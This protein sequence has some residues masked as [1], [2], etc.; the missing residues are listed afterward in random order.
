MEGKKFLLNCLLLHGLMILAMLTTRAASQPNKK[1]YIVYLGNKPKDG[2]S[3]SSLHSSILKEAFGSDFITK[4]V[5]CSYKRS[6]DGFV[7]ELTEEEAL[8]M[9]RMKG[10][11]S[12]FPNEKRELHTTRSWDFMG[13]SQQVERSALESDVIIGVLDTGIWPESDSF[14]DEGFGPPPTN[15]KGSCQ[16]AGGNFTCNNKIIGAQYYKSNGLFSTGDIKSPRDSEG[17]GTHTASTAAGGLVNRATL[18][19]LGSGTARG[20]VPSARIAVYKICWSD[21]CYDAD[22]LAAFDD[23]IADG[24]DIISLSVGFSSP[25]DYFND[26][27]AIGSFHAMR[28][29]VL[30]VNSAGNRGPRPATITNFSPW[31]LSVAASTIDRK[32]STKVQLG[33]NMVYQGVSINTFNLNNQ[34][35]PLIYGG[36][37]PNTTANYTW[38][39]SRLCQLN[40]LDSNLVKGK[41]VLCDSLGTGS[42]PFLAGAAGAVMRD[43]VPSDSAR[44]FPLPAS[45]LE[46][47]DGS[48]V[49]T[50]INSTST[51]TAT[52]FKSNEANDSLAP[53]VVSFSSRGPNPITP[54]ILKPDISAPGVNILAAWTLASHTSPAIGDNRFVPFNIISGTSMACPHVSGSAAYVKSFHPSWSPAAIKSALMTTAFPLSSGMNKDVEF[55]YGSGHVNPVKA[56]NPGLIYDADEIDYI[57]FLCGQGY[58]TRFLEL[59]TRDNTTCS[60]ATNGTVWDLNYPS[61]ALYTSDSTNVSRVF[62]RTVTNVG[63]AMSEYRANVTLEA[64]TLKI[65]V[66][67]SVLSFTSLGQKL[68]YTLT[69]EGTTDRSIVSASLVWDDV[70][71]RMQHSPNLV[72]LTANPT[73]SLSMSGLAFPLRVPE[74]ARSINSYL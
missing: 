68:S 54:D 52:I 19:G 12:V 60:E 10:I 72:P 17:H 1:S 53:Y 2:S 57:K 23:A 64:G 66:N 43:S 15:W 38:A 33:N 70:G 51:P 61:F 32:F 45:Y 65:K 21:G 13:F 9:S 41:I 62:K 63:S 73:I 47:V 35:F 8:K 55:A 26:S 69:I 42:A 25:R 16:T 34:M 22:I 3:K 27:I 44:L 74:S 11:V 24:V 4:S 46:L 56:V 29:G 49:L 28:N 31:S 37:A 5:L 20:G 36:D 67:P 6:F 58:G 7:V 30:T 14:N 40:S 50:Y 48:K 39:S 18:L 71:G 59:V